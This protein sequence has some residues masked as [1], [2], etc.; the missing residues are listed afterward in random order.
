VL[1]DLRWLA[2]LVHGRHKPRSRRQALTA[3]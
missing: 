3:R 2:F 1:L